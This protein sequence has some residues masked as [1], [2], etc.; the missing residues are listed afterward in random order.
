M[1]L[2]EKLYHETELILN[3]AP[4]WWSRDNIPLVTPAG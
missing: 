4:F 2:Q 3:K 1:S